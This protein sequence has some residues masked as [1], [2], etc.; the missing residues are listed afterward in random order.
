MRIVLPAGDGDALGAIRAFLGALMLEGVVEAVLVPLETPSGAVT[1][2]L[3]AD[4]DL[5]Q[6]ANPLAPVMGVNAAPIAGRL[7]VRDPGERIGAVLRPCEWRALVELTKLRQAD[8]DRL[9][10][11][12]IDC[13]GTYDVPTY[14]KLRQA[15]GSAGPAAPASLGGPALTGLASQSGVAL[16][17]GCQMCEKPAA[18]ATDITI[19]LFGAD[20]APGIPVT[21]PDDI[22]DRLGC[23]GW[24]DDAAD[25]QRRR[26]QVVRQ[27]VTERTRVRDERFDEM[28]GRLAADGIEG[29]FAECVRC[30]NCMTV[31]PACYCRTCLFRSP[32]FEHEP[33]H[34]MDCARRKGACRLP[35]DTMMFHLT[36]LNHMALSCVGCGMCTSSCPAELPVGAVFRAVGHRLQ[37]VFDYVPGRDPD[38]PLP[39]VT[40]REDEWGE[41]GEE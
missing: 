3:V 39:M 31:C 25:V 35:A 2:A 29:V 40:F 36:R 27:L 1:P 7:S 28:L 24:R 38:E 32:T 17:D 12:G 22:A 19:E 37:K 10:T 33:M 9:V 14:S 4:R 13:F 34:Y 5:L 20:T 8:L 18:S 15:Q 16:R 30:H 6:A 26:S 23:E 11:I 41:M 21:L